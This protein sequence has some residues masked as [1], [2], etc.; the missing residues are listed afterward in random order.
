MISLFV[1]QNNG[2]LQGYGAYFEPR[3]IEEL[4]VLPHN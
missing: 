3:F 1:A 4:E 2:F